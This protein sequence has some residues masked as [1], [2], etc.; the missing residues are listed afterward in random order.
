MIQLI[1]TAEI[2]EKVIWNKANSSL[3]KKWQLQKW[4]NQG[5]ILP[6]LKQF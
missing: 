2:G 6:H 4:K 1:N 5:G 3:S